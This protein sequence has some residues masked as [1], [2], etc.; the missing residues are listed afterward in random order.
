MLGL[1][2]ALAT[3]IL[4]AATEGRHRLLEAKKNPGCL[5]THV[6]QRRM[7]GTSPLEYIRQEVV[8]SAGVVCSPRRSA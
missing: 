7:P 5:P 6:R 1:V 8:S 3:M 4:V 2:D